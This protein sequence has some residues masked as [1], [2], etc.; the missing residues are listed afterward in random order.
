MEGTHRQGVGRDTSCHIPLQTPGL[1]PQKLSKA[2]SFGRLSGGVFTEAWPTM[3]S[4][5]IPPA[6]LVNRAW[7]WNVQASNHGLVFLGVSPH[8]GAQ[9]ASPH[10]NNSPITQ[11]SPRHLV[12]MPGTEGRDQ[13][14]FFLL[15]H[16]VHILLWDP[17]FISFGYIPRYISI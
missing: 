3:N 4:V 6:C 13:H 12:P 9:H 8:S 5:F 17:N 14:T 10:S 1:Q 16:S 11:E 7:S 15:F 2:P